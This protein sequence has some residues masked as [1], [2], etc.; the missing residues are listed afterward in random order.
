MRITVTLAQPTDETDVVIDCDDATPA[1]EIE[2]ALAQEI[3]SDRGWSL[4]RTEADSGTDS[5]VVTVAP[6]GLRHGARIGFGVD[7]APS[8]LPASGL[9]LHVV[10]GLHAGTVMA[11]P[12]G[13]H[14]LGRGAAIA[15]D[16]RSLSRRNTRITVTPDEISVTDLGSTNGTYLEGV[17]LDP[18]VETPWPMGEV[19]EVGDSAVIVRPARHDETVVEAAEPGWRTFLRPPRIKPYHL[20][21]S[22]EVPKPPSEQSRRSFPIIA[23]LAPLV[24]GMVMVAVTGSK[25]FLIF[26]LM[27][28]VMLLANYFSERRGGARNYKEKLEEYHQKLETAQT[29]LSESTTS[30]Q[31]RLR[32]E[33]PDAAETFVT[34]LLPG[35]RLWERRRHDDDFLSL[36][37]GTSDEPTT[38]SI[39]GEV[40][41]T[42]P[43]LHAVPVGFSVTE[44]G[45]VGIAGPDEQ[46]DAVLRW[47]IAQMAAYHAPRDLSLSFLT[48]RGG[49]E[50]SW[51]SWLP[52]A[53]SDDPEGP[54]A[55]VGNDADTLA[56][57]VTW[58][59][60]TI[61]ARVEAGKAARA[62]AESFPA[63]VVVLHG[64]RGLRA[65]P[66]LNQVLEEGPAVGVYALCVDD[67][68]RSLPERCDA[69]VQVDPV[70]KN[71]AALRRSGHR[72]VPDLLL[73]GVSVRWTD[74]LAR[75]LASLRD[76]GGPEDGESLPDSARLL[77]VLDLDPPTADKVRSGWIMRPMSTEMVLG[78]G[79]G[80]PFSLDLRSD[81][82]HGL[83]AGMTGSG[84]TE[85]LQTMIASLAVA[86]RPDAINFVLVDYKGD[87]AFKDCVKLPHTVGK[88]NDLDPHLVVRALE[89]LKA[90]LK[91][92]EHFLAEAGT[93]DIEDYQALQAKEPDRAPLPR[94]LLVI[95][96][97]AQLS[98][99]LPDFV[100][101]LVSIAQLGRSL[102][103]HLLLATQRP[104]GVVSA[105]IRANTNMR[106]ALRV[107]D[108]ADSTDV[109]DTPDASRIAKSTP[110]RAYARLGAGALQAFQSGRVGGRR[111]GAVAADVP[112]PFV[113]R[114]SWRTLGYAAAKPPRRKET[115]VA[116]TDLSELVSAI[117]EAARDEQI[118]EQRSPW[119]PALPTAMQWADE[120]QGEARRGHVPAF[121]YGRRDVP[122]Q[123]RQVVADLDLERDG[124]LLVTGSAG[125]GRSQLLRTIAASIT[126]LADP[127]DVHLYGIDCGNGALNVFTSLPH[128]GTVVSRSEGQRASRLLAR[129]GEELDR[130]QQI[131]SSEGFGDISEQRRVS[132]QPLPHLVIML[133]R[134][135]GFTATLGAVD[136]LNDVV[137][138]VLREGASL[139]VHAIIT[140]DRSLAY[141][142]RVSSMTESKLTL[143]LAER[144]DYGLVGLRPKDMPDTVLP[145]RGFTRNGN[146]TQIFL[147]DE[148]LG[149][150]AQAAALREI[151]ARAAERVGEVATPPFRVDA[152]PARIEVDA[153]LQLVPAGAPAPHVVAGVGGDE[154]QAFAIDT[155]R[156]NAFIVAGPGRS[157]RSS[158]LV[159]M[160][161][162]FMATGGAVIAMAPRPSPLR[163]LTGPDVLSVFTDP[164]TPAATFDELVEGAGRPVL[165]LIDDGEGL[166]D[167][168]GGDFFLRVAR[169]QV[170]DTFVVLGGHA[171]GVGAGL[172]GWQPE[173]KKA[174]QGLLL[175]PQGISDGELIGTRMPRN[176]LGLPVAV[177]RGWLHLGDGTPVQVATIAPPR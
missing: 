131:L 85:L 21:P 28:P 155:T 18:D 149:G 139:G 17:K 64:Y 26:C 158:V 45:I 2:R 136:A 165:V 15:W 134:W 56:A 25:T 79:L 162:T 140:G 95:D 1:E 141:N 164:A 31:A 171:D 74:D 3:G 113:T 48:S 4:S 118:Q 108:A 57:Q 19:L 115:E 104:S 94:L 105:E 125:S 102:G 34:A 121:P 110:G 129:I 91:Y 35:N 152:L 32:T 175:S 116:G 159:G 22:V 145:G 7:T 83:I 87:S 12:Q 59:N 63:H 11:L 75:S 36:R 147:L 107:A 168:A 52:H 69:T 127:S 120:V 82:P 86:N 170:A 5:T 8:E 43:V 92:R 67:H 98:K 151:G 122:D 84:K 13:T 77:D 123:Q 16:D 61:K 29:R 39:T 177:G 88:V 6:E 40:P 166:R 72:A 44:S 135:E 106:I 24:L 27:S 146:E 174:R 153:A 161:Q 90:E 73:D 20:T 128:T 143:R 9:Q 169:G 176:V 132:E 54:I 119:L 53:R 97:F 99:D 58:L 130:R 137:M 38:I 46:A 148:D 101:G 96:E 42:M 14:D 76:I 138:R 47:T 156:S 114:V 81:G 55:M 41:E 112:P 78:A 50:W 49:D 103:I 23:A 80:G 33:M 160:A 111:P 60:A 70:D 173:M 117:V 157:G 93:K 89:S 167:A 154:L 144:D 172:S 10:G 66:G 71:R 126:R 150:Q 109:L 51:F 30:E 163:D 65:V 124:H 133:D 142:S 37:L 62:S 100:T 68:Q